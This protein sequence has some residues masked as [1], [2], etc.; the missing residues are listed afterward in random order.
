MVV[1]TPRETWTDARLD[2]FGKRVD[3]RFNHIDKRFDVVDKRFDRVETDI[4]ELRQTMVQGFL[5]LV[6]IMLT[7]FLTLAGLIV[8]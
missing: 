7:G 3:E 8:F 1:M 5:V 2:E 6:G 4:R